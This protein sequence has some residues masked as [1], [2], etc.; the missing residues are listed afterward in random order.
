MEAVHLA[1]GGMNGR[2]T[3][4]NWWKKITGFDS[5][6][7][8]CFFK[9]ENKT[10]RH[11]VEDLEAKLIARTPRTEEEIRIVDV[12]DDDF[13]DEIASLIQRNA[14]GLRDIKRDLQQ[15]GSPGSIVDDYAGVMQHPFETSKKALSGSRLVKSSIFRMDP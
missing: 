5:R 2:V 7:E 1:K 3:M 6:I 13:E 8:I 10:L 15:L 9:E 11:R 14:Q 12:A 4:Q